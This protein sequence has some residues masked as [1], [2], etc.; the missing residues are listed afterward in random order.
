M[1]VPKRKHS[2]A[3][4]GSRRAHHAEEAD[5]IGV[6]H[7]VQHG[8][9]FARHLPQLRPLRRPNHRRADG[10]IRRQSV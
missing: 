4:T 7:Q 6:L 1:A 10:V 3:R 5:A 8:H 9:P 2:N